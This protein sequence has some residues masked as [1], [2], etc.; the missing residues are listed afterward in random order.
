MQHKIW[1]ELSSANQESIVKSL[2]SGE[3]VHTVADR[4]GLLSS[5]LARKWRYIKQRSTS[6]SYT[7]SNLSTRVDNEENYDI[8]QEAE[9]SLSRNV[10]S[11]FDYS[12]Y[13][14]YILGETESF[15]TSRRMYIN[16]KK[17]LSILSYTD[18]HFDDHDQQACDTFIRVA[19]AV[20]H[21]LIVHCG[22]PLDCHGLSRYGK[23]PNDIFKKSLK[24]ERA[25]WKKFNS[26]LNAVSNARKLIIAG[27][28]MN[29]YFEWLRQ[30]PAI[31][32]IEEFQIDNLLD[33]ST[34]NYEPM[35]NSIYLDATKS[36]DYPNPKLLFHHGSISRRN[37][38]SSS[39]AES[40]TR[41]YVNSVSGH[42]HR[43][44]VSYRRTMHGQ[45]VS[46]EGGTLRTLQPEWMEF[47][48]WQH[49]CLHISYDSASNYVSINPVLFLDG[50]AYINGVEI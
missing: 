2:A 44:S 37:A 35:V 6:E 30:N 4:Y 17:S 10:F 19:K 11:S 42:V 43:L 12:K 22:D 40:E 34:Y 39:R 7:Q 20:P 23:D 5:S 46:A 1:S 47:P 13:S 29:R 24:V 50:K 3:S 33:L 38:G 28:H 9:D 21:D 25:S 36:I 18:T 26:E 45:I 49:G 8:D 14:G 16:T 31:M 41:G 32:S 27:N 48:D 15:P